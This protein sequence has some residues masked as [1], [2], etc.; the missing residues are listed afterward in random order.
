MVSRQDS[1]ET[2]WTIVVIYFGLAI[3]LLIA[4]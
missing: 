3:A 4:F 2:F 1:P